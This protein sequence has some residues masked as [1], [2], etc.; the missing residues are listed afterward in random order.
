MT[1]PTRSGSPGPSLPRHISVPD[2]PEPRDLKLWPLSLL[3]YLF[4]QALPGVILN[5]GCRIRS[6]VGDLLRLSNLISY[7]LFVRDGLLIGP[8]PLPA[9]EPSPFR[10]IFVFLPNWNSPFLSLVDILRVGDP[11]ILDIDLLST[12]SSS[13]PRRS[14]FKCICSI[15][16][17]PCFAYFAFTTTNWFELCVAWSCFKEMSAMF[18]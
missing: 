6:P 13:L 5:V 11:T 16:R 3:Y 1:D 18:E 14:W 7:L 12:W 10:A 9:I 4:S 8:F 17:F 2:D 15:A